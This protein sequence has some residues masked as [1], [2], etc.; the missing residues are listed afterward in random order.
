MRVIVIY[1]PNIDSLLENRTIVLGKK[2]FYDVFDI[3]SSCSI[4]EVFFWARRVI[5]LKRKVS[6]PPPASY[7]FGFY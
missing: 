1:R 4:Y 2:F 3:P 6:T 5:A 7:L